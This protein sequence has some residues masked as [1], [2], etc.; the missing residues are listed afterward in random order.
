MKKTASTLTALALA[1]SAALYVGPGPASAGPDQAAKQRATK[2]AFG[3]SGFGTDASGGQVPADSD[4]TAY[5]ALGCTNRAGIDRR[6]YVAE[7]DL[8]GTSS[9]EGVTTR[10]RTTERNGDASTY[11][12]SHVARLI[13][14]DGGV[15]SLELTAINS[16]SR[17]F[18]DAGKFKAT[19]TSTIGNITFRPAGGA[20]A[21]EFDAPAPGQELVIPG[22]AVISLAKGQTFTSA[23]QAVARTSGIKIHLLPSD[24]RLRIATTKARL[25]RGIRSG[26]MSGSSLGAQSSIADGLLKVGKTPLAL[27]PCRGTGGKEQVKRIAGVEPGEGVLIYGLTTRH[28]GSQTAAKA[29][30]FERGRVAHVVI[31]QGDIEAR[32]IVGRVNVTR[33][34]DRLLRNIDGTDIGAVT[35]QGESR[36]FPDSDVINIPGVAKLERSVVERN[37]HGIHV[38]SLRITLFDGTGGIESVLN[39]GEASLKIRPAARR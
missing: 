2:F 21:Q 3:A 24:T 16:L 32:N 14:A 27:M 13:L 31:P 28:M 30:G 34:A 19:N 4:A 1:A 9:A 7:A 10:L 36:E 5:T 35:V 11:S 15:G 22:L 39:L 20:P 33:T 26:L 12:K 8:P 6:N 38:I 29:W 18:Y 17:A 37:R 25:E 23:S